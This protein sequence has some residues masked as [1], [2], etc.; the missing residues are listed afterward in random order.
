M[1]NPMQ[2]RKKYKIIRACERT[3]LTQ[4]IDKQMVIRKASNIIDLVNQKMSK[5]NK[6]ET[7]NTES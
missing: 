2:R 5:M 4:P 1:K 3:Y 6:G 7:N